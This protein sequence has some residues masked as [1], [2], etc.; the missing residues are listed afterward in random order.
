[1]EG[2]SRSM[3]GKRIDEIWIKSSWQE[4]KQYT[5]Y[6]QLQY[7]IY[8]FLRPIIFGP[9]WSRSRCSL[10]LWGGGG[11][12]EPGLSLW[13]RLGSW[14]RGCCWGRAW[15]PSSHWGRTVRWLWRGSPPPWWS[16]LGRSLKGGEMLTSAGTHTKSV[17]LFYLVLQCHSLPVWMRVVSV[18]RI[19]VLLPSSKRRGRVLARLGGRAASSQGVGASHRHSVKLIQQPCQRAVRS[20]LAATYDCLEILKRKEE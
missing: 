20:K 16:G 5:V 1:M 3:Q 18:V 11:G 8:M 9:T 12:P 19:S 4:N 14:P 17:P 10:S 7:Q 13:A 6:F 2:L 15:P